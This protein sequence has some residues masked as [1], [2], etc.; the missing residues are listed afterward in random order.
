MSKY[1]LV[2]TV[3]F[4]PIAF[5]K[6]K[7]MNRFKHNELNQSWDN[8]IFLYSRGKTPLNPLTKAKLTLTRFHANKWLDYDGLVSSFKAPVDAMVTAGILKDDGW[9]ITG[10][11]DVTQKR[12]KK[13][14]TPYIEMKVEEISTKESEN[15]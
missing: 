4:L 11:W 7:S 14:E 3:P 10:R 9:L 15:E 12:I 13:A 5:N 8:I 1:S 2:L 6:A